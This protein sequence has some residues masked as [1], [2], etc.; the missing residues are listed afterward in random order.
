[1]KIGQRVRDIRRR[2][3]IVVEIEE[4]RNTTA[5]RVLERVWCEV[6]Y[7]NPKA[8]LWWLESELQLVKEGGA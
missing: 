3:G 4:R 5:D 2:V 6:A 1:M 8:R 7:D